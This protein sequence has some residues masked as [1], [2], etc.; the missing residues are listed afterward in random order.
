MSYILYYSN[1]CEHSKNIISSLSK[2]EVKNKIHFICIDKREIRNNETYILLENGQSVILPSKIKK[3]PALLLLNEN[4]NLVLLH[5]FSGGIEHTY[6]L[7]WYVVF[8]SV[9]ID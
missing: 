6:R 9:D 4:N 2:S 7:I 3:V 1:Y 5:V 8:M